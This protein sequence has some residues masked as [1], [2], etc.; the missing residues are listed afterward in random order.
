M[1]CSSRNHKKNLKNYCELIFFFLLPHFFFVHF[2]ISHF[3]FLALFNK[4]IIYL[5]V[6]DKRKI[7][8]DYNYNDDNIW[9]LNIE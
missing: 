2:L 6:T 1:L 7:N 5:S 9:R 4:C 8:H 3:F